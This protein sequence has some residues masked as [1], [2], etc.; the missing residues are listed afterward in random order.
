MSINPRGL[1]STTNYLGTESKYSQKLS[2]KLNVDSRGVLR[3]AFSPTPELIKKYKDDKRFDW[4]TV[5]LPKMP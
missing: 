2:Y 5:S 1:N 4:K 3:I